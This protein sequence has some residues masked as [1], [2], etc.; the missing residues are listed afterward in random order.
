MK[1]VL[2][3]SEI[4]SFSLLSGGMLSKEYVTYLPFESSQ[5]NESSNHRIWECNHSWPG[6]LAQQSSRLENI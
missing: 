2:D 3:A 1:H 5:S 4:S 6:V